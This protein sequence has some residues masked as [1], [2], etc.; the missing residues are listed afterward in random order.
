MKCDDRDAVVYAAVYAVV[1]AV[2]Y[3]CCS[4]CSGCSGCSYVVVGFAAKKKIS[5]LIDII[6]IQLVVCV[7]HIN[8][9]NLCV[10]IE[11]AGCAVCSKPVG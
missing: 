2:V 10:Q 6:S 7:V 3:G 8:E 11:I 4:G 5:H 1:Y 9:A